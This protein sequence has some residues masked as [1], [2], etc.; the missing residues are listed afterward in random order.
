[1]FGQ[2]PLSLLDAF[3]L[4]L[5]SHAAARS[6]VQ[7]AHPQVPHA[8]VAPEQM[9]IGIR[10]ADEDG[11]R[12]AATQCNSQGREI[13]S[14]T[15]PRTEL[16]SGP[17]VRAIVAI[18]CFALWCLTRRFLPDASLIPF[19]IVCTTLSSAMWCTPAE[20]IVSLGPIPV[21]FLRRHIAYRDVVSVSVV[22]GRCHALSLL[23]QRGLRPWQPLGFALGLTIGKPL[24]DLEVSLPT[25]QDSLRLLVSVDRPEDVIA[26]VHFRQQNGPEVPLPDHM[27][28]TEVQHDQAQTARWVPCDLFDAFLAWHARNATMCDFFALVLQPCQPSPHSTY[29]HF[30]TA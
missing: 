2:H 18:A 9:E 10:S 26:Q 14:G 29:R 13:A 12:A 22:N 30:R 17:H 28:Q 7:V 11:G 4:T 20:I 8:D 3:G 25:S 16:M 15:S 6:A 19:V 21:C 5:F 27:V 1:M 24:L 23:L